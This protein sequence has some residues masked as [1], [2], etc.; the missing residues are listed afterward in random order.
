MAK[1]S[2]KTKEKSKKKG[3]KK[4]VV[5][6]T[7]F[8]SQRNLWLSAL[9]ILLVTFLVFT[10][11]ISSEFVNWDDDVNIVENSNVL[12]F[13]IKKIFTESVIGGFN[14]LTTLTFA[15]EHSLVGLNPKL[16]HINNIIL[17]LI[18]TFFVY[19]IMLLLG[20]SQTGAI[21]AALLFGIHPMRV[22]SVSWATERKDVLFGAF[23]LA[24]LFIYTKNIKEKKSVQHLLII[25]LFILALFSKI[26]AVAL[27]LTMLAVD[28]YFRR[29]L[30]FGRIIEKIPYFALS[31]A[32]GL[33]GIYMLS[34]AETIND[35]NYFSFLDRILIGIYS[36][37]VYMTKFVVPYLMS[38]LYPYPYPLPVQVYFAPIV[39]IGIGYL[40]YRTF[41]N[42][43]RA[44]PFAL[45]VFIFN[46]IFVL[47]VLGAGQGYLADRFTYIPYLG[48]FFL[49][50]FGYDYFTKNVASLKTA[51]PIV[52]GVYILAMGFVN[53]RQQSVWKNSENLWLHVLKYYNEVQSP[54]NNLAHHYRENGRQ[55]EALSYYGEALSRKEK[56]STYNGRGKTYFEK[57]YSGNPGNPDRNLVKKA[58]EDYTRGLEI[59]STKPSTLTELRIN[60]GSAIASTGQ[61]DL[62][63]KDLNQGLQENPE[64]ANGYFNRSLIYSLTGRYE[65]AIQDH[66]SYLRLKPN[67]A[68]IYYER[69][70]AKAALSK[71]QEA[72]ADFTEAI[73]RNSNKAAYYKQR[74]LSYR[75]LGDPARSN[76]DV[77]MMQR[78]GGK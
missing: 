25:P 9:G 70:V 11:S 59:K 74:A 17:H 47:Q 71:H 21:I 40:F 50:G 1:K 3:S 37:V 12:N 42:D 55:D 18:C 57:A 52:A 33:L 68:D 15:I 49:L 13:E 72:V 5:Q 53:I 29:P 77:E 65:Q 2:T 44:I 51:L 8:W 60:R 67:N 19:R 34:S 38:P 36:L 16:Y 27:P 26:Q 28:Y 76:A 56:A 31:L 20:L 78:L 7:G 75:A 45:A 41:K 24:A 30:N 48:F 35:D 63:L 62:A 10:P 73:R 22:E 43:Q 69:A 39:L 66:T 14:P 61:Y 23:Y 64:S 58:I 54:W 4:K 46:V 6:S 32:V